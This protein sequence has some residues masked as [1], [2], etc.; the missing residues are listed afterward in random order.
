MLG[1]KTW[2]GLSHSSAVNLTWSIGVLEC[3]SIGG[4][5]DL[6]CLDMIIHSE[7]EN[8]KLWGFGDFH[9]STTPKDA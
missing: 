7:S 5:K 2:V 3:W 1:E 6:F 9:H 8:L 4:S